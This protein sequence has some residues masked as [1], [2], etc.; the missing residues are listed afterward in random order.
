MIRKLDFTLNHMQN[1]KDLELLLNSSVP[2][3][4]ISSREEKRVMEMFTHLIHRIARPVF[5]WTVTEGLKR[6]DT[7]MPAQLHNRKPIELLTQIKA[8]ATAGVYLLLDFHPFLDD[9][10]HVRLLK[11]IAQ[12]HADVP[13]TVVLISHQLQVPAE[14][15]KHC[16]GFKFSLPDREQIEG[17]IRKEA[18][19]WS[20]LNRDLNISVNRNTLN[21]LIDS[22]TGLPLY[23]ATRLVREA[24][25]NDGVLTETDVGAIMQE[26]FSLLN[27]GGV[28]AF[29]YDTAR[30]AEV[31]G[32][33]NLKDWLAL[34]RD[35]FT[36]SVNMPGLDPPK[37]ILLLGVQGCGKSLAAKAVAGAWGVPLLRLDFG[38]LY[39]KFHGETEKTC[40]N[41]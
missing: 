21:R 41:R 36:G 38:T 22:L 32:L 29:E 19:E 27:Q 1:I 5:R 4:T 3:V 30:F 2:V 33:E 20:R 18:Q 39:N 28:L 31:G 8:T 14:L 23:D 15:H 10:L 17:V 37:G 25:R 24:I 7:D 40:A 6:L 12:N 11:D 13:H 26:K 34:R 9:P 16:A 35:S